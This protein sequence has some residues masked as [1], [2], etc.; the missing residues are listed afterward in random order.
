MKEDDWL[1][2]LH[3]ERFFQAKDIK[4]QRIN[5]RKNV[6]FTNNCAFDDCNGRGIGI[7]L[8]PW[9]SW[10][11]QNPELKKYWPKSTKE[12]KKGMHCS[13]NPE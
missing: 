6:F 13:L 5:I 11:S 7:D 8:Y 9:D 1:W 2:C 10:L 12:L 3:C 4:P